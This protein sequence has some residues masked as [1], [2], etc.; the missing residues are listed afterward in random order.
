M[1]QKRK[2]IPELKKTWAGRFRRAQGKLY[3]P[4]ASRKVGY[5]RA[6]PAFGCCSALFD[7]TEGGHYHEVVGTTDAFYILFGTD[8]ELLSPP[9]YIPF[10]WWPSPIR[11]T[12]GEEGFSARI[13]AL[14]LTAIL[15]EEF[16]T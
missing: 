1:K 12:D 4:L 3:A 16:G 6:G 11:I 8:A 14:E 13:I 9:A 7:Q 5:T 15:C 10:Y 2:D